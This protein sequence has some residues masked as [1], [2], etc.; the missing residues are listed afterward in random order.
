MD[1]SQSPEFSLTHREAF[2]DSASVHPWQSFQALSSKG[3]TR[4]SRPTP[5]HIPEPAAPMI[6]HP[7]SNSANPWWLHPPHQLEDLWF[8]SGKGLICAAWSTVFKDHQ[9]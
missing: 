4:L 1:G 5:F 3:G 8:R 9:C 7:F 2:L 6:P